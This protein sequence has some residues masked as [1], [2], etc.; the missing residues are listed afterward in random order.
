MTMR[1]KGEWC[2][3]TSIQILAY[4][5]HTYSGQ[6]AISLTSTFA[7]LQNHVWGTLQ[8]GNS[9]R[10]R[11]AWFGSSNKISLPTLERRSLW[12]IKELTQSSHPWTGCLPVA[13]DKKG[14]LLWKVPLA[15]KLCRWASRAD[16]HPEQSHHAFLISSYAIK[17]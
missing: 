13:S 8:L 3:T 4:W 1:K 16:D 6:V 15:L 10:C 2:A 5:V 14:Q 9:A 12:L 11:S 17:L 7:H